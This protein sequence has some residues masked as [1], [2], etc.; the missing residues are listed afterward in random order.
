M[1]Y[2]YHYAH[3]AVTTDVVLFTIKD[4]RLLVLLIRRAQD[5]YRG[6][7]ALPG[8]FVDIDEDLEACARRELS[9]ET[10]LTGMY[11]EQL[12]TVGTPG[13][14]PRERV[15]SV[16]YFGLVP[17]EAAVPRAASDAEAVRW[18]P[19]QDPPALAFDH[20]AILRLAHTRLSAKLGY[21]SIA[22]GLMAEKFTLT[23]LQS[24]YEVVLGRTLDKR[25][26]RKHIQATGCIEASAEWQSRAGRRSARLYQARSPGTVEFFR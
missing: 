13:R 24:V 14:D 23:E 21:S 20:D 22:L 1:P 19:V 9:E 4:E 12:C 11:L 16:V 15:V 3:P 5:P 25:N 17:Y 8:G 18:F 26:F 7:W 10:G 6:Y 2:T